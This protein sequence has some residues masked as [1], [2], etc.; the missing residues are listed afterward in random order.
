MTLNVRRLCSFALLA[1]WAGTASAHPGHE[2]ATGF[3]AGVVHPFGGL[4]HLLAML[5]VGLWSAAALPA[6]QRWWAPAA[7]VSAMLGGAG[8]AAAGLSVGSLEPAVAAS[9]VLLG[10]M[11]AGPARTGAIAGA[12]LIAAAGLAHGVAHGGEAPATAMFAAYA[13]GFT[14]ST[15]ALHA[16]GLLAGARLRNLG[17]GAWRMLSA[18][19]SIAGALLLAARI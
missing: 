13:A 2:T 9:V 8:L 4:D 19:V 15:L 16:A 7:F 12:A 6:A 14:L 5:A 1:A 10:L 18:A 11:L 3:I 17:A